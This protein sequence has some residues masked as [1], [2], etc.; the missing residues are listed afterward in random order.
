M[1][2]FDRLLCHQITLG[3]MIVANFKQTQQLILRILWSALKYMCRYT[4]YINL[5]IDN[6]KKN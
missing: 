6:L 1:Q 5:S 2:N 3:A 4:D